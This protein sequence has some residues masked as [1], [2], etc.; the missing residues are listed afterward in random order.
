MQTK[1]NEGETLGGKHG[2]E[3]MPRNPDRHPSVPDPP[4]YRTTTDRGPNVLRNPSATQK[5][6]LVGSLEATSPCPT[7]N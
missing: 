6:P 5:S 1:P 4:L 3:A 7:A 2:A